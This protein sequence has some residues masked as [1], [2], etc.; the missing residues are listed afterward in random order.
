MYGMIVVEPPEGLPRVDREFYLMQGEFYLQGN[1]D[2]KGLRSLSLD[3]LWQETPDFVVFN[4]SLGSLTGANA[5][6]ARVGETVRFFFGVGG[7][8]RTRHSTW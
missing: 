5:L 2:D 7:P 8:T 3:K 6:R 4:G 1:R